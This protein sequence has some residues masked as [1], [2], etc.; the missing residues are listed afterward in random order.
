MKRICS[1][2]FSFFLL[3]PPK[4][5]NCLATQVFPHFERR[6]RGF[7]AIMAHIQV[8]LSRAF[9][10]SQYLRDRS[11]HYSL[12]FCFPLHSE[13]TVSPH[14]FFLISRDGTVASQPS[15]PIFRW[16][17]LAHSS[18]V[19]ILET[20]HLIILFFSAFPFT[21]RQ[22]SRHTGF[23]SFRETE[24]RLHSYRASYSGG[25]VSLQRKKGERGPA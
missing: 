19:S 23:F 24:P 20:D 5:D 21:A 11:S 8:D 13:T 18:Q 7:T 3:F 22:L 12:F 25:S 15:W 2:G 14:R 9:L 16:I 17:C 4:R 6:N 1:C 10:T